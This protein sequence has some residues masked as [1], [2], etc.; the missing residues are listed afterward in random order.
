MNI[1]SAASSL[2]GAVLLYAM[3]DRVEMWLPHLM[4]FAAGMFVYLACSDLIPEL[5]H[6]HGEECEL[7][8]SWWQIPVFLLGIVIVWGLVRVLE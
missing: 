1:G 8:N 2:L 4:S 3:G 7:K 5:H 6:C